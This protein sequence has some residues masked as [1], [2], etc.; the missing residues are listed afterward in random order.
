M[1]LS[2]MI[3]LYYQRICVKLRKILPVSSEIGLHNAFEHN[4]KKMSLIPS[5][6]SNL[7]T[8]RDNL[9]FQMLRSQKTESDYTFQLTFQNVPSK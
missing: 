4:T 1:F 7:R 6:Q 3:S 2:T 9:G 5:P 8:F